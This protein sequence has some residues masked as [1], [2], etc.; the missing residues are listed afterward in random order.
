M[1][2]MKIPDKLE[3]T[4]G[5]KI[6]EAISFILTAAAI[7]VYIVLFAVGKMNGI[8]VLFIVLTLMFCGIFTL[9]SVYPQWTNIVNK[10]Q[11]CTT[12]CF[13]SIRAGCI[14]AKTVMLVLNF[15]CSILAAL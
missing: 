9:C 1:D 14:A 13:H 3:Y 15:I 11:L 2:N 12:K 4:R 10:P 8:V 7:I 5:E 6:G